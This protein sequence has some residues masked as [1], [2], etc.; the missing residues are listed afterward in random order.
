MFTIIV[1]VSPKRNL[2]NPWMYFQQIYDKRHWQQLDFGHVMH[3]CPSTAKWCRRPSSQLT[4]TCFPNGFL[5]FR[6]VGAR[7]SIKER[8]AHLNDDRSVGHIFHFKSCHAIARI[9]NLLHAPNPYYWLGI[10][11]FGSILVLPSRARFRLSLNIP[12]LERSRSENACW[13]PE[14]ALRIYLKIIHS[15]NS[16][17][18]QIVL[19]HALSSVSHLI[20]ELCSRPIIRTARGERHQHDMEID[21]NFPELPFCGLYLRAS[22][23]RGIRHSGKRYYSQLVRARRFVLAFGIRIVFRTKLYKQV[24]YGVELWIEP[25]A[26]LY[27]SHSHCYAQCAC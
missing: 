6:C 11:W 10:S 18:K 14:C 17:N 21:T 4:M 8:P 2:H 13:R 5:S 23:C 3:L 19:S 16:S 27:C 1:S 12:R 25:S 9:H 7:R 24:Q 26:A 22:C 15:R 20:V